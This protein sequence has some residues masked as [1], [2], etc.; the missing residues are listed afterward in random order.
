MLLQK[1]AIKL[2]DVLSITLPRGQWHTGKRNF[3]ALSFRFS[4]GSETHCAKKRIRSGTGDVLFIPD[5]TEY[6]A[7]RKSDENLIVFHFLVI[8]ETNGIPEGF[9]SSAVAALAPRFSEAYEIYTGKE[10]GYYYRASAILYEILA[11]LAGE[12]SASDDADL[13]RRTKEYL[14]RHF[15]E[16]DLTVEKTARDLGVS[17]ALLRRKFAAAGGGSPKEILDGLRIGQAKAL[18]ETGYFSHAEVAARS[19]FSEV[20]YFRTAFRRAVGM[21]P[22]EFRYHFSFL[23]NNS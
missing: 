14:E 5:G 20:K 9:S 11:V 22:S 18:L 10:P 23:K 1:T 6:D 13:V 4:G 2:L 17:T 8:G 12:K 21:T 19:G 16:P 15:V 7:V 3:S